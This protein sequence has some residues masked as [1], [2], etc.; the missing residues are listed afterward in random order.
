MN[1]FDVLIPDDRKV[2]FV[3]IDGMPAV[4]LS[5]NKVPG[6]PGSIYKYGLTKYP[7]PRSVEIVLEPPAPERIR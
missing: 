3:A 7:E 2:R 1:S 6:M 5:I 4:L